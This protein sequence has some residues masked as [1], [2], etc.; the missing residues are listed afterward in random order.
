M[1]VFTSIVCEYTA[2]DDLG[3]RSASC[4]VLTQNYEL[5]ERKLYLA[6]PTAVF[7]NLT[8]GQD[9]NVKLYVV[10]TS[11]NVAPREEYVSIVDFTPPTINLFT[12][13]SHTPGHIT[14]DVNVTDNSGGG[15][16]CSA[17]LY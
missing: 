12:T 11:E 16:F 4:E 15:M 10:N 13:T 5:V 14:V 7:E 1:P 3:L 8:A 6:V 2:E 17:S 9:Y